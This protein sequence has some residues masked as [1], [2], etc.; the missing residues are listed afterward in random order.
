MLAIKLEPRFIRL[1]PIFVAEN[2]HEIVHSLDF[3]PC[4]ISS[5]V[6]GCTRIMALL[7]LKYFFQFSS[8]NN[9]NCFFLI[10]YLDF[11]ASSIPLTE[12]K[13]N[14]CLRHCMRNCATKWLFSPFSCHGKH[15]FMCVILLLLNQKSQ[16]LFKIVHIY[17]IH[18][19][20][21][22]SSNITPSALLTSMALVPLPLFRYHF[23]VWLPQKLRASHFDYIFNLIPMAI[24]PIDNIYY[25]N[26]IEALPT[27]HWFQQITW[28]RFE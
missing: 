12:N 3:L 22:S 8:Q 26:E 25:P 19:H 20:H 4:I 17:D 5:I 14:H 27:Q 18:S 13:K 16:R 15:K 6:S 2:M 21:K 7:A 9:K 24:T 1:F 23:G 10:A 28:L 11:V